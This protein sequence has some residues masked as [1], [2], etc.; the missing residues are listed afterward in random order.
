MGVS[1]V[2]VV[3]FEPHLFVQRADHEFAN[4]HCF[5][6]RKEWPHAKIGVNALHIRGVHGAGRRSGNRAVINSLAEQWQRHRV[7]ALLRLVDGLLAN[8]SQIASYFIR[9]H[10]PKPKPEEVR[11]IAAVRPC[12]DIAT[13]ARR[14]SWASMAHRT[15][16]RQTRT[17]RIVSFYITCAVALVRPLA[18][19]ASKLALKELA[20]APN[21]TK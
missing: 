1:Q 9:Q 16:I 4:R 8:S 11:R 13:Y 20:S 12:G 15:T 14:P 3:D 5:A 18:L 2:W 10:L 19:Y 21:R 17:N 7:A 6:L